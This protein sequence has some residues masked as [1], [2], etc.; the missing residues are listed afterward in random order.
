MYGRAKWFFKFESGGEIPKHIQ[1]FE[2]LAMDVVMI[3]CT[4]QALG[5]CILLTLGHMMHPSTDPKMAHLK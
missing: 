3:K 4:S 1:I 2:S 5:Q